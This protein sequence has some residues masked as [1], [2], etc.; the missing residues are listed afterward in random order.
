TV[1]DTPD[2]TFNFTLAITDVN[3]A[4]TAVNITNSIEL[5][6]NTVIGDGIKV[7][8][9]VIT[10]DALGTNDLSLS[11]TDAESFEIRGMELFYIGASPDFEI[12]AQYQVTVNVNDTTVGETPNA[13]FD[14][15]LAITDVN[16]APTAV[17]LTNT[18]I[19]LVENTVI[20]DGIKVGDIAIT[21]DALGTN[22][23]SLSG[24]DAESFEIRGTELFY[25]GA[26]PDFETKAQYQVTVNVDDETV[27]ATPDATTDFTLNIIDVDET[28]PNQPP[29][30]V[31]V[32]NSIDLAENSVI[33]DG[34]KVGDIVIT[35][36]A[37]GTNDLSLSSTDAESF[38]IR[39]MELFYIGASPDF[40]TK[41]QYQ[42][43]VNVDDT[44]V[45]ATPDAIFDFTL[46]I[47][48][49]NEP[50]TGVTL[51]NSIEL[52]E[53]TVIG[54]GIKVGDIAITDDALGTNALSLSGADAESFEIRGTEL[55]YI[56]A[57]PDFETKAQ[58][59]VTVNVDDEAVGET[60]DATVNFT[61][62]IGD[63]NEA[64]IVSQPI[65]DQ[66]AQEGDGFTFI[67]PADTFTDPD[68]DDT[69]FFSA[70]L[71]DGTTPLPSWLTFDADTLT[72]SGTPT[73]EDVG[74][75]TVGVFANDGELTTSDVFTITIEA[76]EPILP[77]LA[78][79]ATD[80]SKNEGNEGVTPFTF[81]VTRSENI[82]GALTVNY[83]VTGSGENGANADDFGD[84]LP[85]GVVEFAEGE[86]TKTVTVNVSGDTTI[87]SNETFSVTISAEGANIST[88]SAVGTIIND[89]TIVT[90]LDNEVF[91]FR[92]GDG[93]YIFV[94]NEERQSIETN[95]PGFELEGSA[96]NLSFE[97]KDDLIAFNRFQNSDIPG[98]YLY[99]TEEE[100]VSVRE[101]YP[102]FM[103]EGIAFYAFDANAGIGSDIHRFNNNGSYIYVAEAERDSI[104]ANYTQFVYEGVAF[105]ALV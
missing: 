39:G 74:T 18:V 67:I 72:F 63:I 87:E 84:T 37:L 58:Y 16:E 34:I 61:L 51:T 14:F 2:A 9:I 97:E 98:A 95:F 81:T 70:S 21:D 48:D 35:D 55:F 17:T 54:D 4:P 86:T 68:V 33:G 50:P 31:T 40:E 29:T 49:V 38:E 103:F 75:L 11:G 57:S 6:E 102:Q 24:A 13:I 45:G 64:P 26:S 41:A 85:T 79:S 8:D 66:T 52:A 10:D 15:T 83:A 30:A 73:S 80:A 20:G 91:R 62:A 101:Q 65:A 36:D 23:L 28:L 78:I 105:E 88:A 1:G 56:G 44:T 76:S 42:V 93:S 90:V 3:E 100:S 77:S 43:T 59:Q 104:L 25:I 71:E 12:K 5:D 32:T 99:A 69:L 94:G 96:F 47:T 22:A 53:N 60:P 19:E 27:G 89:D 7:G 92:T 82:T 46:A